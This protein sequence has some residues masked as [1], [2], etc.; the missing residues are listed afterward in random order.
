MCSSSYIS[1]Q[2]LVLSTKDVKWKLNVITWTDFRLK[3]SKN[4]IWSSTVRR[5]LKWELDLLGSDYFHRAIPIR[6]REAYP[7]QNDEFLEKLRK[8]G[9]FPILN[10]SLQSFL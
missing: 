6:L 4:F 8:G 5:T 9:S 10:F 2:G 7:H 3:S 1:L